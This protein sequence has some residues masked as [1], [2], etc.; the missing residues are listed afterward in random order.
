MNKVFREEKKFLISINEFIKKS[1]ML[2]QIMIE[3]RITA[4]M[5]TL[6][7][8]CISTPCTIMIILKSLPV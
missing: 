7:V 1:H 6:F 2:S 5:D 3:D 8:P 4:Y